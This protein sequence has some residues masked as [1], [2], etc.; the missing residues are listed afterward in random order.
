MADTLDVLTPTEALHAV[1]R[2]AATDAA[3]VTKMAG[4]TTA[5]SR[6]LDDLCGPIVQRTITDERHAG[7]SRLVFLRYRPVV[8]ITAVKEYASGTLTTLTA[9]T[10]TVSTST[11]YRWD[12]DMDVIYRRSS[13]TDYPFGSQ[14]VLVTYVAGRYADTASV[15]A[16]FKEAAKITLAH[17]WRAEQG[18]GNTTFGSFDPDQPLEPIGFLIPRRARELLGHEVQS[19]AVIA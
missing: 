2:T 14:S 19:T 9:E 13:W 7:G 11:N 16:R 6:A 4:L 10:D 8:S 5:V 1:S 18:A 17:I 15:D 12:A 3:M